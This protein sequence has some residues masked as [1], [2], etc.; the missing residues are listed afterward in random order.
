M[1]PLMLFRRLHKWVGLVLGL[2]LVLWT[3]SGAAMALID[4]HA[5]G[6]EHVSRPLE[7]AVLRTSPI[8]LAALQRSVGGEITGFTLRPLL[9]RH[10][11]EVRTRGGVRLIDGETG[12]PMAV[13]ADLARRIAL[14]QYTGTGTVEAVTRLARPNLETRGREGPLW[15]VQ[16]DDPGDTAFYFSEATGQLLDKRTNAYRAFDVFWMIHIMDYTDRQ[17]FN[18]PLIWTLGAAGA[19]IAVTGFV[20]LF[21]SF[22]RAD[23]RWIPIPRRRSRGS[24]TR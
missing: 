7:P 21:L 17:S 3:V 10:V 23:F 6:G 18:H 22:R 20:L 12:R 2:Q 8:S 11:Y 13:D 19:W 9:D 5:V 4:H 14:Q 1:P 15:R 16:F 24:A